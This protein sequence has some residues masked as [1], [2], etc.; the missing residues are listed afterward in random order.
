M[1]T[2]SIVV[3]PMLVVRPTTYSPST[4]G[5]NVGRGAAAVPISQVVLRVTENFK[6]GSRPV[7]LLQQTRGPGLELEDGPGYVSGDDYL[8][9]LRETEA[10]TYRTVNPDGRIRQ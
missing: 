1:L 8:L 7:I 3:W 9:Y 6:G 2:V 4:S 5:R 10:N